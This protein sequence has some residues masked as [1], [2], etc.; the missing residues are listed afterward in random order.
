MMDENTQIQS[1]NQAPQVQLALSRRDGRTHGIGEF[2]ERQPF[3][4][5]RFLIEK[6]DGYRVPLVREQTASVHGPLTAG[7]IFIGSGE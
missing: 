3:T 4:Q 6:R 1:P 7:I 2:L 5:A